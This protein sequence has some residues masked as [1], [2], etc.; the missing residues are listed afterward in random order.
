MMAGKPDSKLKLLYL[1]ELLEKYTDEEHILNANEIADLLTAE[2]GIVCERKSLYKD[3]EILQSYGMDIVCT[4]SPKRGYFLAS[5]CFELAEIRLLSDAVQAADFITK[6]KTRALL[7]KIES[8]VSV[9]RAQSLRGQVYIDTRAKSDNEDVFYSIDTL[10]C[11]IKS[12]KKVRLVYSRRRLD[13]RFAARK[14]RKSFVLSPYALIWSNDHYYLVANNEKYNNLMNL[15]I[16]R[17]SKVELLD[18]TVRPMSEV[19]KYSKRFDAADYTATTF[20]M[21]SGKPESIELKCANSILEE[22]FDRFG[23]QADTRVAEE[24]S[25]LLRTEAAVN[26]GLVGWLLQFGEKIE[27]VKPQALRGMVAERAQNILKV[28]EKEPYAVS[29]F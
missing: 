18:E 11:A 29:I 7:K 5:G 1:K 21:F 14:E 16:D 9:Y 8:F 28:Y 24:G 20:N 22:M 4:R 25:F 17:I 23:E 6:K 13:E 3:I 15:R 10:D 19:S 12:E 2:H 26:D 27:V